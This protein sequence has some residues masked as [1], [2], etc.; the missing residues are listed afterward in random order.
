MDSAPTEAPRHHAL[1]KEDD[2]DAA[3]FD[4]EGHVVARPG[5]ALL[6]VGPGLVNVNVHVGFDPAGLP[7]GLVR[8]RPAVVLTVGTATHLVLGPRWAQVRGPR[9]EVAASLS[10]DGYVAGTA[11]SPVLLW[12]PDCS[13]PR[14]SLSPPLI[15][16]RGLYANS[17]AVDIAGLGSV[18]LQLE[19][20]GVALSS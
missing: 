7:A 18:R 20:T 2:L 9:I 16:R 5:R 17:V 4:S 10:L 19:R 11:R 15:T 14:A 13:P 6:L 8:L 1:T 12:Q 3:Y